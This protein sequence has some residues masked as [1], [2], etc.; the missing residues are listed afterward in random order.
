VRLSSVLSEAR[1][2]IATGTTRAAAFALLLAASSGLAAVA[3]VSAV[4][5]LTRDAIGYVAGGGATRVLALEAGVDGEICDALPGHA[6]VLASG[7][8][9]PG[10]DLAVTTLPGATLASYEVTPGFAALVASS[11][12]RAGAWISPA[13]AERLG[14]TP[15][16]QLDTDHGPLL[17]AGVFPWP[18]DG[19][20]SR[21]VTAVLVPGDTTRPFDECWA[22]AWPQG[23]TTDHLLRTAVSASAGPNAPVSLG[24]LNAS[25]GSV[26]AD[27]D[28]WSERLTRRAAAV[29]ATAGAVLGV[30]SVRRR[31]LELSGARQA[32]QTRAALLAVVVTETAVWSACGALLATG[33]GCVS[34]FLGTGSVVDDP[35]PLAAAAPLAGAAAAVL[36]AATTTLSV[37][38][39]D[40]V[41]W[42]KDR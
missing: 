11:D 4:A 10:P 12:G 30:L 37:R 33:I 34:L 32:G 25:L 31:R 8:M 16:T 36:A 1:R 24:R 42:F 40:L 39:R 9:R 13:L 17:V 21:L 26:P 35:L 41:R 27:G 7:A 2:D 22:T 14:A 19:R 5:A 18:P 3:D 28:V 38:R 6:D 23:D 29:A 20:D 15:G